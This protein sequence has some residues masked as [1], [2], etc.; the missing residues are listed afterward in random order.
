MLQRK[1]EKSQTAKRYGYNLGKVLDSFL[2]CLIMIGKSDRPTSQS[3]SGKP[4]ETI[5]TVLFQVQLR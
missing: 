1:N 4:K 5:L 3:N 2:T